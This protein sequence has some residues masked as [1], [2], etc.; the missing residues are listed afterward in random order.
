M[1]KLFLILV[2]L[3]LPVTSYADTALT[4]TE[5]VPDITYFRI[6]EFKLVTGDNPTVNIQLEFGEKPALTF[7]LLRVESVTITNTSI[8][9]GLEPFLVDDAD[10]NMLSLPAAYQAEPATK[11]ISEINNGTFGG[12]ATGKEY[13][14]LIIK[15]LLGL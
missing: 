4:T 8:Y 14:E 5:V 9:R 2:L 12:E 3:L 11:I 13:I 6:D 15:T 7:H 1:K 10:G